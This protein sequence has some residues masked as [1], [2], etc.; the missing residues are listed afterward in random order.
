MGVFNNSK[1]GMLYANTSATLV[2]SLIKLPKT[3]Q[4]SVSAREVCATF[5][6]NTQIGR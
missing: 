4:F 1:I 5:V 6:K 2:M 3:E